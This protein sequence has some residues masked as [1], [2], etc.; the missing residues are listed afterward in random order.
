MRSSGVQ[1]AS[2]E[3]GDPHSAIVNINAYVVPRVAIVWPSFVSRMFKK[4]ASF[5]LASLR[6]SPYI[7]VRLGPSLAA[8][9]LV[10]LFEHP[11][12]RV[13]IIFRSFLL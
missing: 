12:Y 1:W 2:A 8:A 7:H 5:V 11:G 10:N 6:T 4:A 3:S 13:L 9:A